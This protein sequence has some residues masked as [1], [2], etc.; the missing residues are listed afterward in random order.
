MSIRVENASTAGAPACGC[1]T[2]RSN[3][4][5]KVKLATAA[6]VLASLGIC[7]ACCL[8][9]AVLISLGVAGSFVGNLES[10]APYKWY[11][12][13]TTVVLLGYGFY[14]VYW[15]PRKT[16]AA[17]AACETCGSSRSVRVA[18]WLGTALALSGIAY[19]YMEPWLTHR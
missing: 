6:A 18:L 17:G 4:Q 1:A 8:L 11:F 13:A 3:N 14:T 16:C 12:I 5:G 15:K 19:G 7:A 2:P 9:P 10:T